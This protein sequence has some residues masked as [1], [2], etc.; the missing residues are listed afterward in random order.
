[1]NYIV[2]FCLFPDPNSCKLPI[3]KGKYRR[4]WTWLE[5]YTSLKPG[6]CPNLGTYTGD[7]ADRHTSRIMCRLAPQVKL[8]AATN[9]VDKCAVRF[10]KPLF[11]VVFVPRKFTSKICNFHLNP[12]LFCFPLAL[13]LRIC[14]FFF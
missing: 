11:C 8:V 13:E 6:P 2:L 3:I 9:K 4:V 14:I 10:W 1:M 5:Q 7:T 12:Q